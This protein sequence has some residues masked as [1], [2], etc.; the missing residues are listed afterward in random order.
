MINTIYTISIKF[1]YLAIHLPYKFPTDPPLISIFPIKEHSWVDENGYL[2]YCP[3]L[4]QYWNAQTDL[5]TLCIIYYYLVSQIL[6]NLA[7]TCPSKYNVSGLKDEELEYVVNK[8]NEY[9]YVLFK[10]VEPFKTK[11]GELRRYREENL[12]I[13]QNNLVKTD[14]II[15]NTYKKADELNDVCKTKQD[16]I[17]NYINTNSGGV[18][19]SP[20]LIREK[21]EEN[22]SQRKA[23]CDKQIRDIGEMA[24]S[25]N[26]GVLTNHLESY[27]R[28]YAQY[29]RLKL[30]S[31]L[32]FK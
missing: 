21:L 11:Y 15:N 3:Y 19:A 5:S 2:T 24:F 30:L 28:N 4:R 1:Y 26:L 12:S 7:V 10:S 29:Y 17:T 22:I 14:D 13:I 6:P 25:C 27:R 31:Q 32:Q 20:E 23:L 16:I 18:S 9:R 8:S